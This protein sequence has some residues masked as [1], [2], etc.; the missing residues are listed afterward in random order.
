MRLCLSLHGK[1]V[2]GVVSELD[3]ELKRERSK[4]ELEISSK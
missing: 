4:R 2:E 1:N 3:V